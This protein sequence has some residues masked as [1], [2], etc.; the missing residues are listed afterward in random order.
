ML[1]WVTERFVRQPQNKRPPK[2][3]FAANKFHDKAQLVVWKSFGK[4]KVSGS[5]S[6]LSQYI[7]VT[8]QKEMELQQFFKVKTKDAENWFW[9]SFRGCE[10]LDVIKYASIYQIY[11]K[12]QFWIRKSTNFGQADM[13]VDFGYFLKDFSSKAQKSPQNMWD[14]SWILDNNFQ[15]DNNKKVN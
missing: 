14:R 13:L 8:Q 15:K 9:I 2:S 10:G 6:L 1:P 11:I 3:W 5:F 4:M 12:A 7:S